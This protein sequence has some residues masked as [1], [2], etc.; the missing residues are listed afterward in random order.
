MIYAYVIQSQKAAMGSV[1]VP[2]RKQTIALTFKYSIQRK[3]RTTSCVF[4]AENAIALHRAERDEGFG[5]VVL[6]GGFCMPI[7]AS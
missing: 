2:I 1:A 3:R 4:L 6:H 7:I 5:V